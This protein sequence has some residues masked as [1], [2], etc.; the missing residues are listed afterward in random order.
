MIPEKPE[1]KPFNI[2]AVTLA[3]AAPFCLLEVFLSFLGKYTIELFYFAP[4]SLPIPSHGLGE[5]SVPQESSC[6][7]GCREEAARLGGP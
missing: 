3:G 7:R 4:V 6:S 1:K 2:T 5:A